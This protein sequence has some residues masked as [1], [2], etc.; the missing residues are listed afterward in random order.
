MYI[1]AVFSTKN[2]EPLLR[3]P[4]IRDKLHAYVTGICKNIGSNALMVSG[5]ENHIHVLISLSRK[6]SISEVIGKVKSNSTN[7][8]KSNYIDKFRWQSGY[9]AFSVSKSK[10]CEVIEYIKKQLE[11][12]RKISFEDEFRKLLEKHGIDY[13][14]KYIWD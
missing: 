7:W 13:D 3:D 12:H 11:H 6:S 1:H 9:G 5:T 8:M 2:R 4:D 10:E 14:E